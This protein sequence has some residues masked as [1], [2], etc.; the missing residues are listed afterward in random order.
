MSS[1]VS[2]SAHLRRDLIDG[3][4]RVDQRAVSVARLRLTSTLTSQARFDAHRTSVESTMPMLNSPA[5]ELNDATRS[6]VIW[7]TAL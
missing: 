2:A 4:L 5:L 1:S 3:L 7:L 6:R